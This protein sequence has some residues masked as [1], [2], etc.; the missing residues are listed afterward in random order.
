V[1]HLGAQAVGAESCDTAPAAPEDLGEADL[2][3]FAPVE[4]LAVHL[5]ALAIP[6]A[7]QRFHIVS[8]ASL[9][10]SLQHASASTR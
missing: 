3:G 1:P 5:K 10:T 7:A 8:T 9:G 6:A 4:R 2:M